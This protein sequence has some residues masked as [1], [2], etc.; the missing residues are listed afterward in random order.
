[1]ALLQRERAADTMHTTHSAIGTRD[2]GPRGPWTHQEGAFAVITGLLVGL[3]GPA[4]GV[5]AKF[6][7]FTTV[8]P[9][10]IT[11]NVTTPSTI[12]VRGF[13]TSII[14]VNVSL[15]NFSHTQPSDVDVLLVGPQGQT[16]LIMSD[17]AS[18]STATNDGLVLDDQAATRLPQQNDLTSGVFQP[19]N[20]DIGTDQ[21]S[22]APNPRIPSP[23]PKNTAL[24]IFNGTNPNG[25]W[26]LFVDDD[27]D[28]TPDTSGAIAGGWSLSI[29]TINGAPQTQPERFQAQAG[30]TLSVPASGVL[31]NDRD[32][33]DDALIAV[34]ER[35][36]TQ[37]QLTL[38]PDGSF[39][40]TAKDTAKDTGS[41]TYTARDAAGLQALETVSIQI[42][43]TTQVTDTTQTPDT[44]QTPHKKHKKHKK[45]RR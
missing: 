30:Q 44:K 32:P 4:L 18:A 35:E 25:T 24:G 17:V 39:T 6:Q 28:D 5:D 37:G 1:M 26:T 38:Q 31:Q 34:L 9:I 19:T 2:R 7:P 41:F 43:D 42:T 11:D 33:D 29:T 12:E 3:L 16:A 36:P 8:T 21:D 13:E 27:D 22:F 15:N 45:H 23:L 40:Y 14:D 10:A 20:Y